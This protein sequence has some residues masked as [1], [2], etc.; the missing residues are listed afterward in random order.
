MIRKYIKQN[1]PTLMSELIK[2]SKTSVEKDTT[3]HHK[4]EKINGVILTIR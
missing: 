4:L 1:K 2:M 3:S